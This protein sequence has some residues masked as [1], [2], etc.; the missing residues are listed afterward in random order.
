[1]RLLRS[2]KADVGWFYT[3]VIIIGIFV[4]LLLIWLAAK[5][6]WRIGELLEVF[7]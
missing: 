7:G 4:L 1:M 5:S 2:R 6:G 3:V